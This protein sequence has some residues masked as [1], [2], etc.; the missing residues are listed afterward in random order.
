MGLWIR[1]RPSDGASPHGTMHPPSLKWTAFSE[2]CA[3]VA[4]R[5]RGAFFYSA[6]ASENSPLTDTEGS[7]NAPDVAE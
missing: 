3:S 4:A 1:S 7:I 2:P 5:K 6:F